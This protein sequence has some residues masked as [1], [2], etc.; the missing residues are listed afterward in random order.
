MVEKNKAMIAG[1]KLRVKHFKMSV[2]VL[3]HWG[4]SY[5]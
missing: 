2:K 3:Y 5:H 4:D 1:G